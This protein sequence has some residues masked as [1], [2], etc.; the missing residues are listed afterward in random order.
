ME[1]LGRRQRAGQGSCP[2]RRSVVSAS[3]GTPGTF[4]DNARMRSLD[5]FLPVYEF[6][7]R[8]GSRSRCARACRPR[9]A[10]GVGRRDPRHPFAV[11]AA[12]ARAREPRREAPFLGLAGIGAVELE[13]EKSEGVVLGLAGQFGWLRGGRLKLPRPRTAEEFAAYDR[14]ECVR[15]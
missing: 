6:S 4:N 14:P 8:H 1:L 9:A 3:R 2:S 12:R 15:R 10:R 13:N 7:E 5:D 11:H